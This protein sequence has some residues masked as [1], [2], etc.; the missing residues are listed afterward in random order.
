MIPSTLSLVRARWEGAQLTERA[1]IL[2][3]AVMFARF[4]IRTDTTRAE[5]NFANWIAAGRPDDVRVSGRV[6]MPDQCTRTL[7][8]IRE[9]AVPLAYLRS[10]QIEFHLSEVVH[11]IGYAKACFA[12][13]CAGIGRLG[14][15]DSHLARKHDVKLDSM[16]PPNGWARYLGTV[17]MLWGHED[18]AAGQ[19]DEWLTD[20]GRFD[21]AV[22]LTARS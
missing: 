13:A 3:D 20:R 9:M 10:P 11:G 22:L 7:A 21:H 4:T 17:C 14:C 1:A 19:W 6:F 5:R 16:R 8:N 12:A 15:I 2:T 18:S